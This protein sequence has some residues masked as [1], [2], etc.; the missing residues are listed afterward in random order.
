MNQKG[1]IEQA[2]KDNKKTKV[3]LAEKMGYKF[4]TAISNMLA[5]GN[6]ELDT[7]CRICEI[8]DY[9]VTIQPKRRSGAR[10]AGQIVI[11]RGNNE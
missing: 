3:W 11:E 8:L 9:E 4:P 10:P 1:A 5:R 7:L 6:M 2:L